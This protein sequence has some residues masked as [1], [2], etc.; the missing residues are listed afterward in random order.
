MIAFI[1]SK[2]ASLVLVGGR[3]VLVDLSR[4]CEIITLGISITAAC[5]DWK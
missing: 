2:H 1:R 3:S 4:I 5:L